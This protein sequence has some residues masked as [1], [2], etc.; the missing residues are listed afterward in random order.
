MLKKGN[1]LPAHPAEH[2]VVILGASPKEDRYANRAQRLLMAGGYSVVPVHPKME[3]IE[4]VAVTHELGEVPQPVH[5]LT[6]YVG[7][8]R[9]AKL[10]DVIV[11]LRPARVIFNPGSESQ[12][13][14]DRLREAG[15]EVIEGCTL[16]ML[17]TGQF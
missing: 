16:V 17:R 1:A 14:E 7:P 6:M 9:S 13:L 11:R 2:R 12:E 4:G 5:T 15:S 3:E 8:E 10:A